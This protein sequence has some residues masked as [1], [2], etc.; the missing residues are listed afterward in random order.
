M[1]RTTARS[2]L[3]IS[4]AVLTHG[5]LGC[6]SGD[7]GD[8]PDTGGSGGTTASGGSGGASGSTGSAGAGTISGS[9]EGHDSTSVAAAY[10]IGQSDDPT[11][12][13]VIYVFDAPVACSDLS[14][15]G[16]D[17][18]I[19]NATGALEMKLIG[20]SPAKYAVSAS[21]TPKAG[22]ASV[23]FTLSSTTTTP[24]EE[25]SSS[26]YVQLDTLESAKQATGSFD[27]TFLDGT[28]TGTFDA[29]WCANGHEP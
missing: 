26:G 20:T 8:A 6:S 17:T 25:A 1:R 4:V 16:W 12:T 28:L 27:L 29:A 10:F 5:T 2:L 13:T 3:A 7:G 9:A 18:R 15:P 21:P 14:A 23:N 19:V 11:N 22:E 24:G